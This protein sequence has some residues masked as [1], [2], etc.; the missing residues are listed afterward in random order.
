MM[1]HRLRRRRCVIKRK[2]KKNKVIQ[3]AVSEECLFALCENGRIAAIFVNETFE[4]SRILEIDTCSYCDLKRDG[5]KKEYVWIKFPEDFI[6]D[7]TE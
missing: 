6:D 7:K 2:V 5:P 3:I 4:D 1:M